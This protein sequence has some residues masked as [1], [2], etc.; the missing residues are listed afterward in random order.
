MYVLQQD[1]DVLIKTQN[2]QKYQVGIMQC[3][4]MRI[5]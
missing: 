4:H 5:K 2:I 1:K 3:T